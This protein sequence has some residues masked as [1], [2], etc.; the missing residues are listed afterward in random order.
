MFDTPDFPADS[1]LLNPACRVG[2]PPLPDRL[3]AAASRAGGAV[4]AAPL[5]S[6]QE[7]RSW[8][9]YDWSAWLASIFDVS[10]RVHRARKLHACLVMTR[11][12]RAIWLSAQLGED[13]RSA[14]ILHELSHLL[15]RH[16]PNTAY[17]AD[18]SR[19]GAAQ[20]Q[21]FREQEDEAEQFSRVL[22]TLLEARAA[23]A[24]R[25]PFVS[26]ARHANP[27]RVLDHHPLRVAA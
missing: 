19:L 15:L 2:R 16:Q 13:E 9:R 7:F 26:T 21:L 12:T 23:T 22:R 4:A 11:T 27:P 8:R 3:Q 20:V 17:G 25:R 1:T 10:I 24:R 18:P 5:P 14:A 6:N